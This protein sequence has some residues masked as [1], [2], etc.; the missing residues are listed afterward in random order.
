M[1]RT[2]G[3]NM[4]EE[5]P[6]GKEFESLVNLIVEYGQPELE[7]LD[8]KNPLLQCKIR[9]IGGGIEYPSEFGKRFEGLPLN[10]ALQGY[11]FILTAEIG[12]LK[13]IRL[14]QE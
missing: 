9:D 5:G 13:N 11:H 12:R 2:K 10:K 6:M 3:Y 14:Y 1:P 4:E 7:K 8:P